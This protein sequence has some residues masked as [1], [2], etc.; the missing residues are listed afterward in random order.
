ME[1]PADVDPETILS[2]LADNKEFACVR[3]EE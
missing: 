1:I 3:W 2:A